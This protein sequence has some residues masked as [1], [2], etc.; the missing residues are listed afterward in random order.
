MDYIKYR[1]VRK[2]GTVL[3]LDNCGHLEHQTIEAGG[4]LFYVFISDIT[5]TI[6]E[7]QKNMLLAKNKYYNSEK[8]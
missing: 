2:N 3:W 1:I 8:Q 5:D 6:T 4:G 7:A